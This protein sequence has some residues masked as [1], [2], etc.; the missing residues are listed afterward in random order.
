MPTGATW[1]AL[2][3]V[4]GNSVNTQR[5]FDTQGA[6]GHHASPPPTYLPLSSSHHLP[7]R[8]HLLTLTQLS[9]VETAEAAED[10]ALEKAKVV[11]GLIR[12]RVLAER[13]ITGHS[14][15]TAEASRFNAHDLQHKMVE[16][17]RELDAMHYR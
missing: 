1:V 2:A 10:A 6:A 4:L 11:K 8:S 14:A 7:V 3:I 16:A 9:K 12:Q 15:A 17:K 5:T 13:R